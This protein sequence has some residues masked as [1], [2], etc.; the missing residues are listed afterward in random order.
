MISNIVFMV[1]VINYVFML[2]YLLAM[3]KEC[4]SS[5]IVFVMHDRWTINLLMHL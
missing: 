1:D 3:T 4:D 5:L 2:T